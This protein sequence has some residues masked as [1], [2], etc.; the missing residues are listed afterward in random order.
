MVE[1]PARDLAHRLGRVVGI[2]AGEVRPV[3]AAPLVIGARGGVACAL[4][5]RAVDL[6]PFEVRDPVAVPAAVIVPLRVHVV[7]ARLPGLPG[8]LHVR[9]GIVQVLD[10]GGCLLLEACEVREAGLVCTAARTG[11]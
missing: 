7:L 1:F 6:P 2:P 10:G 5:V 3:V 11:R 9:A 4:G 8:L